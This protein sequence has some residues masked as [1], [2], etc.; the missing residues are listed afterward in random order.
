[1]ENKKYL[2]AAD[3]AEALEVSIPMAYR[4]IRKLND[5][6]NVMGY[7]TVSGRVS[8]YFFEKKFFFEQS[9]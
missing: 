4:I 3:V 8:K 7:L 5:E 2:R 6:L 1:M 9:A